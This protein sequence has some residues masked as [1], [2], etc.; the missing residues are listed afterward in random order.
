MQNLQHIGSLRAIRSGAPALLL[1]SCCLKRSSLLLQNLPR[2][3][4]LSTNGSVI[5]ESGPADNVESVPCSA[6]RAYRERV[7]DGRLREDPAQ[8]EVLRHYEALANKL[9]LAAAAGVER[10]GDGFFAKLFRPKISIDA[11]KGLYVY[12]TVGTGK[13]MLMDL[14]YDCVDVKRKRRVHFNSFMLDVHHRIHLF[15]QSFPASA[16]SR[17]DFSYDPIAAVAKELTESDRLLCFDEFQVTDIA[18]AMI[19]KRLFTLMFSSGVVVVAT[20]NRPPED[21]Y[22]NGLQRSQF[23]PFI[24]VLKNYCEILSLNTGIDYRTI[25]MGGNQKSYY[26]LTDQPDSPKAVDRIF[27]VL[28]A[29]QNDTVRPRRLRIKGR[30]VEFAKTC[31]SILDATYEEL[32]LRSLGPIDYVHLSRIFDTFIIRNVPVMSLKR[33]DYMKRFI[34]LIDDLYDQKVKLVILADA[35]PEKLFLADSGGPVEAGGNILM[36]DLGIGYADENAKANVF[37]GDEELFAVHRTISRLKEMQKEDYWAK[38]TR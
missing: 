11:P 28:T 3:R 13:T 27:K 31:G 18:D 15:K 10:D 2:V 16:D 26:F 35:P 21:L 22:K 24:G 33:R 25:S 4:W 5:S 1:S 37:T 14:F 19:L 8:L 20:S 34:A 7:T 38:N 32:C 30:E 6:V 9:R 29:T 12:G 23:V 17:K 36:D